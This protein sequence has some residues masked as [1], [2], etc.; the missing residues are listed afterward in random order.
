MGS[1]VLKVL[2]VLL[3]VW[4][5]FAVI[6]WLLAMLKL[7]VFVGLI[8]LIVMVIVRMIAKSGRTA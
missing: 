4:L 7:F 2:G 3:A 5:A 1:V 8:A 6:G